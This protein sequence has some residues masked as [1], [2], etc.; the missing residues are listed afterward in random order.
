MI[1][2]GTSKY[3]ENNRITCKQFKN[4]VEKYDDHGVFAEKSY[5]LETVNKMAAAN[6]IV[7]SD[8]VRTVESAKLLHSHINVIS[9]LMF[10]ETELPN[11]M[12]N[13]WGIK[14]NPSLWA[15]FLRCL[16]ICGYSQQCE[17][18]ISAKQRAKTAAAQLV[19]YAKDHHTVVLVGHGFFNML[20]A[21]ELRNMGWKG[22]RKASAKH[23][24]CTTYTY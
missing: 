10:R 16:W 11:P 7:T 23:W 19:K 22:K 24:A 1:R 20:I 4:W 15:L 18:F 9:A 8:L 21:K 14:L 13:F 3:T 17:S 5:P 12:T 2:H 6:M